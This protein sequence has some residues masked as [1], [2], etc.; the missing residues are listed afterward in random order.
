MSPSTSAARTVVTSPAGGPKRM[1]DS[2]TGLDR[3]P[4]RLVYGMVTRTTMGSQSAS[5]SS[6]HTVAD[7]LNPISS[8]WKPMS[9]VAVPPEGDVKLSCQFTLACFSSPSPPGPRRQ[10]RHA[11][12]PS[13]SA[14]DV[15]PSS[16]VSLA[17]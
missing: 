4:S 13:R 11:P 9:H 6:A 16:V 1:P 3:P 15:L 7:P 14:H 17:P 10:R 8:A 5:G 2:A 12:S